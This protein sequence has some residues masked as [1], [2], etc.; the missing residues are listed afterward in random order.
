MVGLNRSTVSM[1]IKDFRREGILSGEGPILKIHPTPARVYLNEAG[2]VL[3]LNL[4]SS[5]SS[6]P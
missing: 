3:P 2:L 5:T 4:A 6:C 1:L